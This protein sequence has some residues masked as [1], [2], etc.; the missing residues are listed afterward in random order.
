MSS[1]DLVDELFEGAS[2]M[3]L[4]TMIS[5]SLAGISLTQRPMA[6]TTS[7]RLILIQ[8][9]LTN[10]CSQRLGKAAMT[11]ARNLV[12]MLINPLSILRKLLISL[13]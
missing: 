3:R 2:I 6:M 8:V 7:F 9:S 13:C 12:R 11:T 1:S 4:F 10:L 5:P